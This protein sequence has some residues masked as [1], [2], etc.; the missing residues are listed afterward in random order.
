[1]FILFRAIR[2]PDSLVEFSADNLQTVKNLIN[3]W[4]IEFSQELIHGLLVLLELVFEGMVGLLEVLKLEGKSLDLL[5]EGFFLG[6]LFL[7]LGLQLMVLFICLLVGLFDHLD[8]LLV[9]LFQVGHSL[10][11]ALI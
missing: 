2:N 4:R 6:L 11:I 1:M 8:Q 5:A 9:L 10:V 3:G 7:P